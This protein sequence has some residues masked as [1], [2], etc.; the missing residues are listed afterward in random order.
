[1]ALKRKQTA[2]YVTA[3]VQWLIP[4]KINIAK[5][6]IIVDDY[7]FFDHHCYLVEEFIL[8]FS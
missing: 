4:S 8:H 7:S 3:V 1:M 5:A 2:F 6:V